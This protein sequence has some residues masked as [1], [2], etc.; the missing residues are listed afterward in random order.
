MSLI[1]C[2]LV[3]DEKKTRTLLKTMLEKFCEGVEVLGEAA[4]V[5]EAV[6]LIKEKQPDLVFLD[7]EMPRESGFSLFKYFDELNFEV[8]F[9]TAY[10]QYAVKA[11]KLAALDYLVKPINLEELLESLNRFRAKKKDLK[12]Q[13]SQHQILEQA[14]NQTD[15]PKIALASPEGISFVEL[16]DILRCQSDKSYT[17]FVLTSGK[18]ICTSK[19]LG[20]YEQILEE[21]GFIRVHRS[22]LVNKLFIKGLTRG[23][24]PNLIMTQ[25]DP[26]PVS[27]SKKEEI[28]KNML[29]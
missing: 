24:N 18:K 23:K 8:V 10:S 1:K 14:I 4:D 25:G 28:L 5:Q 26:V 22:H 16:D 6:T 27:N 7:V 15:R 17:I 12:E 29:G 20:E 21:Y 2:I 3:D 11:I 19:N 13:A 9:T